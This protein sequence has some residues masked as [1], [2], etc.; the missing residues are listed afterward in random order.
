M[1]ND[2]DKKKKN[3]KKT[4][5]YVK[6]LILKKTTTTTVS[7]EDVETP[8]DFQFSALQAV[9]KWTSGLSPLRKHYNL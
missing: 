6:K 1:T 2:T 9:L 8:E 7:T 3:M 4:P 5:R